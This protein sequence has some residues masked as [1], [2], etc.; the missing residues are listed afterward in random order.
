MIVGVVHLPHE[1]RGRGWAGCGRRLSQAGRGE[2]LRHSCVGSAL[3]A[4]PAFS[5]PSARVSRPQQH[6]GKGNCATKMK[7]YDLA[8]QTEPPSEP[9]LPS[10]PVR[11]SIYI[12]PDGTVHFGAL[13]EDLVP[14]AA[15]L[16][17]RA[18]AAAGGRTAPPA[19]SSS[20]RR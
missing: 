11:A 7:C 15:A 4:A 10:L 12:A 5:G 13:F 20:S 6:A 18:S 2:L 16:S 8:V 1:R 14:V 17:G 19:K 9:D 3:A